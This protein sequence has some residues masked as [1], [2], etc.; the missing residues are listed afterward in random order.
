[1]YSVTI[2]YFNNTEPCGIIGHI[3][4][5]GPTAMPVISDLRR[6]SV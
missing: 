3:I 5:S 6:N 1:M 4:R 2:I